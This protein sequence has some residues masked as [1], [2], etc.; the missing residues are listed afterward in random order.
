MEVVMKKK[1]SSTKQKCEK[2]LMKWLKE[3]RG[4]E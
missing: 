3:R 1:I 4:I 2:E